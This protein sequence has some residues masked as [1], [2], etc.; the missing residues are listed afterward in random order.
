ME[1]EGVHVSCKGEG[2]HLLL[3]H[4][5][6]SL[7]Y[8][9]VLPHI[10]TPYTWVFHGECVLLRFLPLLSSCSSGNA[11]KSASST[12]KS[13]KI[14]SWKLKLQCFW[15]VN[16]ATFQHLNFS[17]SSTSMKSTFQ[18]SECWK[19]ERLTN[20]TVEGWQV[21]IFEKLKCWRVQ[22]LKRRKIE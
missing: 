19:V 6:H 4:N 16:G 3:R 12:L 15:I 2:A 14:E 22:K 13:W 1:S 17:A 8:I 21:D 5:R 20:W 11:E 10:L 18:Y 7:S 9:F